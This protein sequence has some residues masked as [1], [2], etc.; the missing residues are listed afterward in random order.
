MDAIRLAIAS[1]T[2]TKPIPTSVESSSGGLKQC[3]K[4]RDVVGFGV[5]VTVGGGI[6]VATGLAA[7]EAGPGVVLS[8]LLAA[9]G[10]ACSGLCYAEMSLLAPCAGSSYSFAYHAVGELPAYVTGIMNIVGNVLSGAAVARGWAGYS[11]SLLRGLGVKAP[12]GLG[13][14]V[15]APFSVSPVA[16]VL[17]LL[18]GGINLL[19][20]KATS[21]LNGVITACSVVLLIIFVG[22][23]VPAIDP[24]RWSPFLP[25]GLPG[26]FHGAG[27][28]F[29]SYI[30]FDVLACLSEEAKDPRIVP[31]GIILTLIITTIL[32]CATALALTGLVT[33]GEIDISAPLSRAA[34]KR[35]HHSLALAVAAGAVGNTLTTVVGTILGGPR[36][37]YVMAQDGLL[38]RSLSDVNKNGTPVLGLLATTIPTALCAGLFEFEALADITSAAALCSFSLVCVALILLRCPYEED[39]P[40]QGLEMCGQLESP[41]ELRTA[42]NAES[43]DRPELRESHL[44]AAVIG[45]PM[46][47]RDASFEVV[48]QPPEQQEAVDEDVAAQ[49][50]TSTGSLRRSRP[51]VVGLS[52]FAL[53]TLSLGLQMR[54]PSTA[55]PLLRTAIAITFLGMAVSAAAVAQPFW[56]AQRQDEPQAEGG[57]LQLPCMPLIPLLG[58]FMNMMLLSQLPLKALF[59]ALGVDAICLVFYFFYAMPRSRLNHGEK[60]SLIEG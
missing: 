45:S 10:C 54:A 17:V 50:S 5:G 16:C 20:T 48:E 29:F 38:P 28:V 23:S 22:G 11:E 32:Y 21:A 56:R 27:T 33:P 60:V 57:R 42:A 30:G 3:L 47:Q 55:F 41:A 46:D 26:V 14:F 58:I 37:C 59:R 25:A 9:S 12:E 1:A 39:P 13:S 8:F 34:E 6:F 53:L 4:L 2:R 18:L 36:I 52:A 7:Q 49:G 40:S 43:W 44:P 51:V 15:A 24:H 31:K 19:G 35:G